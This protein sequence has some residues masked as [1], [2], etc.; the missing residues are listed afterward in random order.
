MS[1]NS[2]Y[3]GTSTVG[4]IPASGSLCL[5]AGY[6]L[7][8][9]NNGRSY[10]L[11]KVLG[12][13][14]FGITYSGRDLSSGSTVAV[15]EFFPHRIVSRTQTLAVRVMTDQAGFK[16][17]INSFIKEAQVLLDLRNLSCVVGIYDYFYENNT[18]YYVMEYVKGETMELHLHKLG[19]LQPE[20]WLPQYRSLMQDLALIHSRGIIHRDISP[21][22]IMI[23]PGGGFKLI[24]FGSARSYESNSSLTVH[25]KPGFAPLEQSSSSG[26]GAFTDVYALA[27][28]MYYSFSGKLVPPASSRA[29][30]DSL[31]PLSKLGVKISRKQDQALIKALAV[32]PENRFQNMQEFEQAFF[33]SGSSA[34]VKSVSQASPSSSASGSSSAAL[35][36]LAEKLQRSAALLMAEPVFP[37]VSALFVLAAIAMQF[38]L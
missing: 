12:Q 24:D 15:K 38:I 27:A 35:D 33:G 21:D 11:N 9:R 18:A 28:T 31:V 8:N 5:P 10:Q 23:L 16:S 30:N 14:G 2:R 32:K 26:Q 1:D 6:V 37:A 4:S 25:V 19:L 34:P 22:N 7:R 36:S 3:S 29:A 20:Q 13:G 17:S